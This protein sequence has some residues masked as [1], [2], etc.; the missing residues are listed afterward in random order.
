MVEIILLSVARLV[1]PAIE[2]FCHTNIPTPL[3]PSPFSLLREE[4]TGGLNFFP[5]T[6]VSQF[7]KKEDEW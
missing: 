3:S 2:R 1:V 6:V 5:P 7:S 4:R